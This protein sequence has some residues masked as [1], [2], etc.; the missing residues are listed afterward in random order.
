MSI[1]LDYKVDGLEKRLHLPGVFMLMG[2]PLVWVLQK[3]DA[4]M[5]ISK[6]DLL[7]EI[8]NE[9]KCSWDC[10]CERVVQV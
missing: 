2:A 3:V 4:K 6:R 9:D 5:C 10:C 1:V 7:G 8:S